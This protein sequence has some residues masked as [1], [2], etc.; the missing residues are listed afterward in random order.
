MAK[1]GF[2]PKCRDLAEHFYTDMPPRSSTLAEETEQ[3]DDLAQHIQ[4]AVEDWFRTEWSG[5]GELNG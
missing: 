1:K 4:N 3:V 5:A 2:D